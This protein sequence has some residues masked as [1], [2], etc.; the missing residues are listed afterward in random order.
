MFSQPYD[1]ILDELLWGA[2]AIA[3]AANIKNEAGELNVKK[4]FRLL[5]AG[6]IPA[7]KRGGRYVSTRRRILGVANQSE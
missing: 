4:A 2:R 7:N 6:I 1:P 3:V 5:S